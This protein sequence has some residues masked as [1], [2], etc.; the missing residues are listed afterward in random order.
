MP[1]EQVLGHLKSKISSE[2]AGSS[3]QYV[4]PLALAE[5]PEPQTST[6]LTGKPA[7]NLPYEVSIPSAPSPE[8][9][10]E[11][12][13]Q[14]AKAVNMA[15]P[16]SNPLPTAVKSTVEPSPVIQTPAPAPTPQSIGGEAAV[17]QATDVAANPN[18][19][20]VFVN[21]QEQAT[22]PQAPQ[23]QEPSPVSQQVVLKA[24]E[25]PISE[26]KFGSAY[27]Q[28]ETQQVSSVYPSKQ[29]NPSIGKL[30][31]AAVGVII[32]LVIGLLVYSNFSGI[33]EG[34]SRLT[35]FLGVKFF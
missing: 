7:V 17:G 25:S 5:K 16:P 3:A 32:L 18:E 11:Q 28:S 21:F 10:V 33:L 14:T 23:P 24:P 20:V 35:Q 29:I 31:I 22:Q 4:S 27:E 13:Q 26:V 9:T 30:I 2:N 15:P 1:K 6:V 12:V 8:K 19:S 34:F